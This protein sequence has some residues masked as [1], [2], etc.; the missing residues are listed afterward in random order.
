MYILTFAVIVSVLWF[1]ILLPSIR[2]LIYEH[3]D[4]IYN[5]G[6]REGEERRRRKLLKKQAEERTKG[7]S[8]EDAEEE[9]VTLMSLHK[10]IYKLCDEIAELK[11][12]TRALRER[13]EEEEDD[14]NISYRSG[15]TGY[16]ESSSPINEESAS[17][18]PTLASSFVRAIEGDDD[19][20]RFRLWLSLCEGIRL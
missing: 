13:T 1:G 12:E 4:A 20:G 15:Y 3:V 8:D 6:L 5:R 17:R 18:V 7:M 10:K 9:Q 16:S 2:G 11:E 14:D 19:S